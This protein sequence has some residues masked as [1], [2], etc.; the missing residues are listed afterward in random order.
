MCRSLSITTKTVASVAIFVFSQAVCL[1]QAATDVDTWEKKLKTDPASPD[2]HIGLGQALQSRGDFDGAR[3]E[4]Q[5]AITF[6]PGHRNQTAETL[7]GKLEIAKKIAK[8]QKHINSGINLQAQ[9]QYFQAI[10]EYKCASELAPSDEKIFVHVGQCYQEIA[11]FRNAAEAF[12]KSLSLEPVNPEATRGL[13]AVRCAQGIHEGNA[14][15]DK[16]NQLFKA[17]RFDESIQA[18]RALVKAYPKN[19]EL[20]FNLATVYEAKKGLESALAE[21]KVAMTLDS[22]AKSFADAYE[23]C[24]NVKM[25]SVLDE[26]LSLQTEKKFP[27]AIA[28][29]ENYLAM[30]QRRSDVWFNSATCYQ[31]TGNF[32]RTISCYE[33]VLQLNPSDK[34]AASVLSKLRSAKSN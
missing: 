31:S 2:V 33:K 10:D 6:S 21:Y 7:L 1:G 26:A 9:K 22:N 18:Y 8:I 25:Q 20:H 27:H 16:G 30:V 28:A 29:Y 3:A 24:M 32:S 17:K 14:M 12:Q 11:D 4:Y 13:V 15:A 5:T 19:A 23:R 34:E